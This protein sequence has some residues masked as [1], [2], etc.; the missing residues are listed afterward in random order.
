[1][2]VRHVHSF[3]ALVRAVLVATA[4]LGDEVLET[5]EVRANAS[6]LL[7]ACAVEQIVHARR[8]QRDRVLD[9]ALLLVDGRLLFDLESCQRRHGR[10]VHASICLSLD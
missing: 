9:E 4:E 7:A 6:T 5:T 8:L 1:M 3:L 10:P 2:Y